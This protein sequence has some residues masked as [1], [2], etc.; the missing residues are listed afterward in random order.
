MFIS[1][2]LENDEFMNKTNYYLLV[3][4]ELNEL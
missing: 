2:N 4:V 1:C 3:D